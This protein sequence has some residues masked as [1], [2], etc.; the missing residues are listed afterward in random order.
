MHLVGLEKMAEDY[1]LE[2]G[3]AS[4]DFDPAGTLDCVHHNRTPNSCHA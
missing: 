4:T 1:L 3:L 2:V